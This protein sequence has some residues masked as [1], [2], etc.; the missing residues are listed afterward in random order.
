MGGNKTVSFLSLL[1]LTIV[2][3][4]RII[5]WINHRSLRLLIIKYLEIL[6]ML[7]FRYLDSINVVDR[8]DN[9]GDILDP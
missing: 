4:C 6:L 5:L 8:R 7:R 1:C 9:L 3:N 2:F